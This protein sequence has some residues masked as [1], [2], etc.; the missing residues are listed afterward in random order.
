MIHLKKLPHEIMELPQKERD[1]MLHFVKYAMDNGDIPI[2][3]KN[4]SGSNREEA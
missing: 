3:T 4:F 2:T 1:M